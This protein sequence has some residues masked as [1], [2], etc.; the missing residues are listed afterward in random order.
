M[1]ICSHDGFIKWKV[2]RDEIKEERNGRQKE[3][4]LREKRGEG[5]KTMLEIK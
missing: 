5:Q 2:E 4:H 3:G 1:G